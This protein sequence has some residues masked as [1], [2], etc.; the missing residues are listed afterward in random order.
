MKMNLTY[1]ILVFT[2]V[3]LIS[4]G[5]QGQDMTASKVK[6]ANVIVLIDKDWDPYTLDGNKIEIRLNDVSRPSHKKN[7]IL[8]HENLDIRTI[9][10][11]EDFF[12][13]DEEIA[14]P[15]ISDGYAFGFVHENGKLSFW[16]VNIGK[17]PK[18][19]EYHVEAAVFYNN[20]DDILK[21]QPLGVVRDMDL[22]YM[23]ISQVFLAFSKWL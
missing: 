7:E 9:E 1:R 14:Q 8:I 11:N 2:S 19:R 21:V 4:M 18:V 23:Y 6:D 12:V 16:I 3:M 15:R 22:A 5:V 10:L 20:R 17:D 13:D